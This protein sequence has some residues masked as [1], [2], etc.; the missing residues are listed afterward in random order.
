MVK[1]KSESVSTDVC[2]VEAVPLQELPVI[3]TNAL[4]RPIE[5]NNPHQIY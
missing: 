5:S 3:F 4:V 2:L 1:V